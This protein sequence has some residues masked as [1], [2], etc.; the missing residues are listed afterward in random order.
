MPTDLSK[1]RRLELILRQIESLP[2]LSV[3]A[4]RLL[5]LTASDD[6]NARQIT[7]L[8]MAD[9]ALTA[10][11]LALCRQSDRGVR[12]DVATVDKAVVLLGFNAVRN[13]V[14][15]IKVFE[16]F[17]PAAPRRDSERDGGF[18]RVDFWRHS[19]A[20]GIAAEMI[21][22]AHG[23]PAD[24]PPAEAFVAGLLH[25]VGKV[26]LDHVL[27]KSFARVIELTDLNQGNIAEFERRIVGLDHHTAGKRIA[28][29]WQLPHRLQDCIWLHGS[30]Y[31]ALP[32]LDHRR[33]IGLIG[34]ADLIVRQ[35]HL[36]YSGNFLFK[37]DPAH[38][39]EKLGLDPQRV[40]RVAGRLHEEVEKRARG[41]GLED[42]PSRDLFLQSIQQANQVL[43]RLNGAL[44]R[45]SRGL[46]KQAQVLDAVTAFHAAAQ[47]GRSVIDVMNVVANNAAAA[48]GEGFYA[49]L[50]QSDLRDQPWFI[51]QYGADGQPLRSQYIDPPPHAP[52]LTRLGEGEPATMNLMSILPWI[53]DFLLEAPD[54]REVKLLPLSC[55]WGTAAVLLHNQP[56]LPPW[57]Q[58]SALVS[59]WGAAIAAAGQHDGARRLGEALADANR[60]LAEAQDKL[61]QTESMARL[62]EMAA[63]AAHEMNNPLAVISGRSQLLAIS[64]PPGSKEQKAAQT[65]HEQSH[66]LSDLI[67]SLRVFA[68]PPRTDAKPT[69]I[70]ALLHDAIKG[71]TQ[72]HGSPNDKPINLQIKSK[73]P[74]VSIDAGQ[75]RRALGELIENAIQ[76]APRTGVHITARVE[77]IERR[78]VVQVT[79]DGVGMDGHTLAHALDPFFSAKAAGR[80][81]GMGLPRAQQLAAAHGG[82]I[83]LRSKAGEGTTASLFL[84]LDEADFEADTNAA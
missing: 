61:L 46:T 26:A 71:V 73:L 76:A 48:L 50:Q 6:S 51:A 45:R 58:L 29:Q 22:T 25:D 83:E 9:Q 81:V 10:K 8:V 75:I 49:L 19:L 4:T 2:T 34:L 11:V 5:S 59:T 43:G 57:Q 24:L 31:E 69:D 55:G 23:A 80:R 7:E 16:T 27:P 54:L 1:T 36:G 12:S 66:R 28:E 74:T 64:L 82:W 41:L 52:D 62:G 15:S 77:P 20:V 13:A 40:E 63:G 78:L 14:L 79:D 3:V 60:A 33:L 21:A 37:Q 39:A 84:P 17:E 47:P 42:K 68:D 32:R 70:G 30:A 67:T 65:I 18:D 44:E 56:Q 35:Q 72:E 53:S 38:A